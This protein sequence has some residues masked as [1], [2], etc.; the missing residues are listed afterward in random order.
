MPTTSITTIIPESKKNLN[1]DIVDITI[2]GKQSQGRAAKVV[3]AGEH[4][5]NVTVKVY[6]K[7]NNPVQKA[8]VALSG[9]GGFGVNLT[10]S[11]GIAN[12][13]LGAGDQG[14]GI[15]I[16]PNQQ[17]IDLKLIVKANGFYD[18]EDERAVLLYQTRQ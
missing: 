8:S 14:T 2:D 13:K 6:D 15:N 18:Y 1:M 9:G 4:E 11:F 7:N 16:R 5:M 17:T 10:D 3:G 12:I